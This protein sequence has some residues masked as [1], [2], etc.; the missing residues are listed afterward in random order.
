M[1]PAKKL[2][3]VSFDSRHDRAP[4]LQRPV[5]CRARPMQMDTHVTPHQHPWAQL[6]CCGNGL[7]QVSVKQGELETTYIV[8]P[9]RAV[10]IPPNV[11]HTVT[12][13]ETAEMR[14]VDFHST[15]MPP[16]WQASRVLVVSSLLRELIQALAEPESGVREQ[17]LMT[18]ASNELGRAPAQALGVP[19]PRDKRLRA[20]CEAI[21]AAPAERATLSEWA[22]DIGAS[23]R[24]VARLFRTELSTSFQQ[25]RQQA[26][27]AHALPMLAKGMSIGH[28]A[29][30]TGYASDSAFSAMFKAAMG[31]PPSS[32]QTKA[33]DAL[34][35][36]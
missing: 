19:L 34:Q 35:A 2:N 8:P 9:T 33:S 3:P 24:T 14:T 27:L 18:L 28:V 5:R 13:L 25:W 7:M 20:L 30:A 1:K 4:T 22:V 11:E 6:S 16:G 36:F 17:A 12:V 26:V 15:A 31:Q 32:F 10:W 29:A 21:L 23:E